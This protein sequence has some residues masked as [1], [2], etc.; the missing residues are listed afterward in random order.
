MATVENITVGQ[1]SNQVTIERVTVH[2]EDLAEYLSD[3]EVSDR[4]DA[5]VQALR[6]GASALNLADTT[7]E[8]EY[9]ERRFEEMER[10]FEDE[11]EALQDELDDRFGDDGE[12]SRILDDH[13]GED[14]EIADHLED[15]FG[16]EG[17]FAERLE[18]ELGQGGEKIREALDPNDPETPTHE[19]KQQITELRDRLVGEEAREEV[20]EKTS[21]KGYDFEDQLEELLGE[22]VHQT[23]NRVEDTSEETGE[24]SESK[25]GDFVVTLGETGQQIVVE[26]KN[27]NFNNTVESEMDEAIRNR[28]ADY[29]ILVASSLEYLPRTKVGWFSE[30]DQDYVVV[31]LSE[32]PD[33][34]IEPRFLK[35]AFHWARTRTLLS[36][37]EVSDTT[38]TEA[39]KGE[40]DGLQDSIG[41]F[42][43]IREQCTNLEDSVSS[44]REQLTGIEEEVMS[45][46][47]RIETELGVD[48]S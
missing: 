36:A 39:I 17:R 22:L 40:L 3:F 42:S 43:N 25:K 31:A 48:G 2:D 16:E 20:R 19:L 47:M 41:D 12:L 7:K 15:T 34:E 44:I 28:D 30:I 9:V 38:D 32:E 10:Q 24:I 4:E 46:I 23:S 5:L 8:A 33:D 14:G 11:L 21:L 29:G 37:V 27:G 6:V 1:D 18:D 35:F 26:A 13:L 45:R